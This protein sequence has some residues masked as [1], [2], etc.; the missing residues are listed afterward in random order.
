[1]T[2]S[3][4]LRLPWCCGALPVKSSVELV[5]RDGRR[6]NADRCR[7]RRPRAR[8]SP[9]PR[10]SGSAA[11]RGA[12]APLGVGE[13]LVHRGDDALAPAGARASSS[14][15]AV[16]EPV[17][18]ELG[19]EVGAA[20]VRPRASAPRDPRSSASSSADGGMT[21][22]SSASSRESA[23]SRRARC[24]RRRRGARAPTAKPTRGSAATTVMSG[25]CV[26]PAYGSLRIQTS[27]G[28]GSRAQTAAT[29][30]G[31][32]PRWTGMCSACMTIAARGVEER[33]RA[34]AALLDVRRE[35]GAHEHG[36]HLLG[37]RPQRA[38]ITWSVIGSQ[39]SPSRPLQDE[40]AVLAS[41]ARPAG[42]HPAAS[43]RRARRSAGP[44]SRAAG[45]RVRPD[46]ADGGP[47]RRRRCGR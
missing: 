19:A 44:R 41:R 36:A 34:V 24:R 25:R 6:R 30:A 11:R 7:R 21:T 31:I 9:R 35:G 39:S 22:P 37:D 13:E 14:S 47:A 32:A 8:P 42:G 33:G 20:L 38:P 2:A 28:A 4:Q 18:G 27:P 3:G 43:R 29:A 1:M 45:S 10:P 46:R 16:G 15:R 5:T 26:P 40:G 12:G 17:R 23:G